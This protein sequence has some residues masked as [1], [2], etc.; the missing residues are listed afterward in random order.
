ML[1]LP[2][3]RGVIMAV[4]GRPS[5]IGLSS[6]LGGWIFMLSNATGSSLAPG[7]TVFLLGLPWGV[8]TG[9]MKLFLV[10]I[11]V[12]GRASVL[13]PLPPGKKFAMKLAMVAA[14]LKQETGKDA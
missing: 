12:E 7:G 8:L 4:W 1:L 2:G 14:R 11:G 13:S 3:E 10:L 5:F 9:V 6:T